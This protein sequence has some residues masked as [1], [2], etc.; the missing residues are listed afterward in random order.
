MSW[1]EDNDNLWHVYESAIG[2][3]TTED[4]E[5]LGNWTGVSSDEIKELFAMAFVDEEV[6]PE[7]R[8][9]ARDLWWDL[10]SDLGYD[11]SEFDW[12]AW[13]EWYDSQ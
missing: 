13:R 12:D 10:M 4:I 8:E 3:P 6:A 11:V 7:D 5:A 1:W 2:D 9:E